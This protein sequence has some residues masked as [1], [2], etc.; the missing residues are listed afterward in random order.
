MNELG[1]TLTS[2][3]LDEALRT[4]GALL[5]ESGDEYE[6]ALIGGGALLLA[7]LIERPTEDLDAVARIEGGR[8]KGARPF[9]D[10]LADAIRD[11]ADALDLPPNWL[12]SGAAMVWRHGLPDGFAQRVTTREFGGL[13]VHLASRA[14]QLAFKLDAAAD[15][16]P[17]RGKHLKDLQTLRPKRGELLAARGWCNGHR[18]EEDQAAVDE[19]ITFLLMGGDDA[20]V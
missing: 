12:N 1:R 6:L 11:V 19:V 8:W 20:W 16:W 13:V 17:T 5:L 10:R 2:V 4:L 7:G 9:P 18:A 14:D 15:K 3:R